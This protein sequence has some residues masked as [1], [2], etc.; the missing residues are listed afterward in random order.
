MAW[1]KASRYSHSH[2]KLRA[3]LLAQEPMCRACKRA[4]ATQ[5]DHIV[6][7][8]KGGADE[9]GN[10]QPLCAPCHAEKTAKESAEAKGHRY[11]PRRVTGP[12]GWP[13]G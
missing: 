12:D 3:L 10:L 8:Y 9:F 5:A 4:S 1:S 11:R 7:R 6:P 13:V 2:R